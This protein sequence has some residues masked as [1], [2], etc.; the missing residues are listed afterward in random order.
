MLLRYFA[1]LNQVYHSCPSLEN[2]TNSVIQE[3]LLTSYNLS[4]FICFVGK[5]KQSKRL[6]VKIIWD[7]ALNLQ[8]YCSV[9]LLDEALLENT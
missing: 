7:I 1:S 5:E 4:Y 8:D 9:S 2:L 6:S 3:K